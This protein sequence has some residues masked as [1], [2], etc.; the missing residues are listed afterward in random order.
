MAR[1]LMR[2]KM[3][4]GMNSDELIALL[5]KGNNHIPFTD[6]RLSYNLGPCPGYFSGIDYAVLDIVFTKGRV[7]KVR[8]KCH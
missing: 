2:S 7:T 5:G 3:L 1:Q 6:S 4:I 8:K